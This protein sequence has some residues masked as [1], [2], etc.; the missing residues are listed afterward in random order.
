MNGQCKST[1]SGLALLVRV[2]VAVLCVAPAASPAAEAAAPAPKLQALIITGHQ[3]T[4]HDW[5]GMEVILRRMLEETGRFE[6]RVTEEFR[7]AT[8]ETLAPY[9]VVLI[10]FHGKDRLLDPGE[11]R[12]G[13]R[14]ERALFDFVK[15]GKGVVVYHSSFAMGDPSWPEF[16]HMAGAMLRFD[17]GSRRNPALDFPVDI[18]DRDDPIT[19]GLRPQYVDVI[20]DMYVSMR[21]APGEAIHVLATAFDDPKAYDAKAWPPRNY[22]LKLPARVED[23]PGFG[24]VHPVVWTKRYGQGR[25]YGFTL[26]HGPESMARPFIIGLLTRGTEWAA[27][28]QVT[29]PLPPLALR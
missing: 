3:N 26:G 9:D 15:S 18:V 14:A 28:G 11:I 12:W 10:N 24:K 17:A 25:V 29:I 22:P 6:V 5:R 1:L 20:D 7:G 21:W 27:T 13:E 4:E 8:D 2:V 23:L 16:E 19:H